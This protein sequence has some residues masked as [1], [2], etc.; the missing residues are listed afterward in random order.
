MCTWPHASPCKGLPGPFS[1]DP[2]GATL[3]L[4]LGLTVVLLQ[5]REP[6]RVGHLTW[7]EK[8][9]EAQRDSWKT[10]RWGGELGKDLEQLYKITNHL[11]VNPANHIP[12]LGP[13]T[14]EIS[15]QQIG[16]EVN[17]LYVKWVLNSGVCTVRRRRQCHPTPALLPGKSH[18]WRSLVG[19][20][21]WGC[22][23]SDTTE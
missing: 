16:Y 12:S 5:P 17:V 14:R 19:Y 10:R 21:P 15:V 2:A 1:Q 4:Q 11:F 20:S 3:A 9:D 7:A 13:R 6:A 22:K 8:L 23:E 18:G